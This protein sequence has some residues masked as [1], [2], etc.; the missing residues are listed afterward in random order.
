MA[1]VGSG[2]TGCWVGLAITTPT[3]FPRTNIL[4]QPAGRFYFQPGSSDSFL[5]CSTA[6]TPLLKPSDSA[7]RSSRSHWHCLL[8]NLFLFFLI[9]CSSDERRSFHG[10]GVTYSSLYLMRKY[11]IIDFPWLICLLSAN[12]NELLP[13]TLS[14]PRK[15]LVQYPIFGF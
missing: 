9:R 1:A 5:L 3:A 14:L 13:C 12:A 10:L 8:V 2:G 15:V 6:A 4:R 7:A 11:F